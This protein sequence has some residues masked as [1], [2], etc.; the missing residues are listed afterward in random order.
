MVNVLEGVLGLLLVV[1][2]EVDESARFARLRVGHFLDC[3]DIADIVFPRTMWWGPR[4]LSLERL[5]LFHT[6]GA[7]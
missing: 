4:L 3:V 2:D 6:L 1:P 5:V 7:C